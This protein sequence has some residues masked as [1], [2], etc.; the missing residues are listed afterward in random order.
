M[1]ASKFKA[2]SILELWTSVMVVVR[3]RA[4]A[5]RGFRTPSGRI[6]Y[7]S[8]AL[9]VH[10]DPSRR[11]LHYQARHVNHAAGAPMWRPVKLLHASYA[12]WGDTWIVRV[13]SQSLH[14]RIVEQALMEKPKASRLARIALVESSA[15]RLW[16]Q[17]SARV[18][19][20]Q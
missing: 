19:A 3:A 11:V 15:L 13:P 6:Q 17:A 10:L 20:V 1:P 2:D 12:P 8:H 5:R 4:S 14:V 18:L 9:R 7:T 16:L